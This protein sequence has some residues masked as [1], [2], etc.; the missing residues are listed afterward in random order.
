[1]FDLFSASR[2]ARIATFAS[3]AIATVFAAPELASAQPRASDPVITLEDIPPLVQRR[4]PFRRQQYFHFQRAY[5]NARTPPGAL[6]SARREYER[7]FG[8]IQS[9]V[10]ADFNQNVWSPI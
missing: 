1:M 5:P 9:R 2:A 8:P 10:S 3:V 6:Q 4:N 7:Q